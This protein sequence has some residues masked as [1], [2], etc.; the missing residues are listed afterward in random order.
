MKIL[1][2]TP[3]YFDVIYKINPHMK[4]GTV[5]K[6]KARQQWEALGKIYTDIGAELF[7]IPGQP[8]L[9]DMVFSANQSLPFYRADGSKAVLLS[10]MA[11]LPR[12]AEVAFFENW[13]AQQGYEI[14]RLPEELIFE[15]MGDF[16]SSADR[17]FFWGGVGPRSKIEAHKEIERLAQKPVRTLNLVD[18]DF[19]HLDTCLAL[20]N[21]D[22]VV[23]YRNAFDEESWEKIVDEHPGL[24]E[25]T[26]EEAF[27]FAC[28]LHCP[29]GKHVIIEQGSPRLEMVL[30]K[31]G[32]TVIPVDTSEFIKSGGSVFCMK[33][34]LE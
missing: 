14:V 8:G 12:R 9:P 18:P 27:A 22:S 17:S 5:D 2:V 6:D 32:F 28:N 26:K 31:N 16:L 25:V 33:L 10:N 21:A 3:E 11:H 15:G 24:I 23:A 13:F 30:K 29:D 20:L 34:D 1:R 19:Y 4:V 7:E